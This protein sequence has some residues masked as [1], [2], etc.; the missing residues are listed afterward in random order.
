MLI[1]IKLGKLFCILE[2]CLSVLLEDRKKRS[3]IDWLN[4]LLR[5]KKRL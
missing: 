4:I 1:M 5:G 2:N 3:L